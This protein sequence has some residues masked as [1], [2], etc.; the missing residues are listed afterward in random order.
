MSGNTRL[1]CMMYKE[2]QLESRMAV[3]VTVQRAHA[4]CCWLLPEWC[5]RDT[6]SHVRHYINLCG[7]SYK[8]D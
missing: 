2:A 6:P 8:L 4:R 1:T 7:L 5:N 3:C